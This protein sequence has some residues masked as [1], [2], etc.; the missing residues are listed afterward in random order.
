MTIFASISQLFRKPAREQKAR[1]RRYRPHG[2]A[3]PFGDVVDLSSTG[4]KVVSQRKPPLEV[5]QKISMRLSTQFQQV[6]VTAKVAWIVADKQGCWAAGFQFAD[7]SPEV[8]AAVE[9]LAQHGFADVGQQPGPRRSGASQ[10]MK[11][12]G[13]TGTGESRSIL[14]Q[15]LLC[16]DLYELFGVSP[17]V[18]TE[19]LQVAYRA[20][21]QKLH[22]D[23][24]PAPDAA[25]KF[26]K[27]TK[28]YTML[29][30]PS[31]RERYDQMRTSG[32]KPS[33]G[34]GGENKAA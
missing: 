18:T 7:L 24:N 3:T 27:L 34:G 23:H 6:I 26:S 11:A 8:T 15:R 22:P 14:E 30:D 13:E 31:K 1:A 17:S 20:M 12:K 28:A 33:A 16:E 4:M 5:G 2:F 32:G 9:A 21:A 10:S 29:K 19:E 25:E